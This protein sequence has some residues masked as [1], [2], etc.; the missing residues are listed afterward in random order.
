M[1]QVKENLNEAQQ[2]QVKKINKAIESLK[3]DP[4]IIEIVKG[5]E[6]GIKTTQN[7]Y[8]RYMSFLSTFKDTITLYIMSEALKN[9]G[10]NVQG[11][12]SA[13]GILRG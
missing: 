5:I 10:G 4:D 7:N 6:S 8:E 9:N 1:L 12:N 2:E 13:L 3:G 11:I